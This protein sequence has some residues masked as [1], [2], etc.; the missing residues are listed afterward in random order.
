[1]SK[2]FENLTISEQ[3]DFFAQCQRLLIEHHPHSE[4]LLTKE[5]FTQR[6]EYALTFIKKYKGYAHA[7]NAICVL[8]NK[9]Y[10]ADPRNPIKVIK[11]HLYA[12]PR[13]LDYNAISI[14]FV[15]FKQ[16][17]DC[18]GFCKT[19]Y[20]PQI[21]YVVFVRHNEVK[22]YTTEKLLNALNASP[23]GLSI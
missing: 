12:G 1:M 8:Y 4:F 9:I 11:D 22:L 23:F 17:A 3:I 7:D 20:N 14:D 2:L 18:M 21:K 13:T 15:V 16:L 5:N 19:H 6:K 10:V